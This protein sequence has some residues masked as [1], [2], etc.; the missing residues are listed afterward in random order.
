MHQRVES[1]V[2]SMKDD[3]KEN[4]D[5]TL[6]NGHTNI[7]SKETKTME[8]NFLANH[9]VRFLKHYIITIA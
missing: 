7:L 9:L 4:V 3:D 2:Q 6:I 8:H 5:E 1:K